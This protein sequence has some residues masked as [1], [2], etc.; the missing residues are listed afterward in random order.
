MKS[1][2]QGMMT[3]AFPK[4]RKTSQASEINSDFDFVVPHPGSLWLIGDHCPPP[5]AKSYVP[6]CYTVLAPT[7]SPGTAD[8]DGWDPATR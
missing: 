4:C 3:L 5:E 2:P 1:Q 6:K 7:L 8:G